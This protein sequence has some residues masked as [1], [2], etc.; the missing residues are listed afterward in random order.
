MASVEE[1]EGVRPSAQPVQLLLLGLAAVPHEAEIAQHDDDVALACPAQFSFFETVQLAVGVA[2]KIYHSLP[3][4]AECEIDPKALSRPIK[5]VI[6]KYKAPLASLVS[7]LCERTMLL[8]DTIIY[9]R[10]LRKMST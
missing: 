7:A 10:F 9:Y 2:R 6:I 8:S 3:P 1:E 4:C 5:P